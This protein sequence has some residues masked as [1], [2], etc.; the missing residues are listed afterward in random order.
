[1]ICADTGVKVNSAESCTE[2]QR[3][4]LLALLLI[5][6]WVE[7]LFQEVHTPWGISVYNGVNTIEDALYPAP[8]PLS[9]THLGGPDLKGGRVPGFDCRS[10]LFYMV[11]PL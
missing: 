3:L 1:M 4:A 7:H 2:P 10:G 9:P 6:F 5:H 11:N 8:A